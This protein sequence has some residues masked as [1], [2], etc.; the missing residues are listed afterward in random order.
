MLTNDTLSTI[1]N[2][3]STRNFKNEQIK[4]DELQAVLD[5][6]IYAPNAAN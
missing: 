6:G 5:V 4:D 2:R 1:K 3:R